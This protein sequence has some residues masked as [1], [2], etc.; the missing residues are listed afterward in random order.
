MNEAFFKA[1]MES[2]R[3]LMIVGTNFNI[4]KFKT[5]ELFNQWFDN[6]TNRI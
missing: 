2:L 5:H 3:N 1:L 4:E 6:Y